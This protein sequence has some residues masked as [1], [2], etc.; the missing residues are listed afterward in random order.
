M[1]AAVLV[2]LF[3]SSQTDFSGIRDLQA[4]ATA[5]AAARTQLA[6]RTDPEAIAQWARILDEM[7]LAGDPDLK[8]V[9][10][11]LRGL[12]LYDNES[13]V[14]AIDYG[15]AYLSDEEG[16]RRFSAELSVRRPDSERAIRTALRQWEVENPALDPTHTGLV[17]WQ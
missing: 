10:Q 17:S 12:N 4:G 16:E 6:G 7:H 9:V 5:V 15:Y 13:W 3:A 2:N 14:R 11:S 8:S 1:L